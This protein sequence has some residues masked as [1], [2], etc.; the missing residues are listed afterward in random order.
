[1]RFIDLEVVFFY[2]CGLDVWDVLFVFLILRWFDVYC[3][4]V[5]ELN[6]VFGMG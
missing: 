5:V 3:S 4:Y 6:I 2:F 1:M